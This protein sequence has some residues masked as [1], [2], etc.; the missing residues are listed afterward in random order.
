MVP[1][2]RQSP[3]NTFWS[4][5]GLHSPADYPLLSPLP[6]PEEFQIAKPAMLP[7]GPF[8][9]PTTTFL[10]TPYC[11]LSDCGMCGSADVPLVVHFPHLLSPPVPHWETNARVVPSGAMR[12]LTK[13]QRLLQGRL[14]CD[15]DPL[16]SSLKQKG[17][18]FPVCVFT[19]CHICPQTVFPR[20]PHIV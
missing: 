1:L 5:H 10:H 19:F 4:I 2:K 20:E 12:R 6:Q 15:Q 13:M 16:S 9:A 7:W 17:V 11:Y 8:H 18:F 14:R 3:S